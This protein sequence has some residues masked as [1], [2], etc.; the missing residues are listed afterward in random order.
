LSKNKCAGSK[1]RTTFLEPL[2]KVS[3]LAINLR[4][5]KIKFAMQKVLSANKFNGHSLIKQTPVH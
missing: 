4:K 1:F 2:P 3:Q 5:E